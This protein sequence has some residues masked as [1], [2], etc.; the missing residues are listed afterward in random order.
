MSL[1]INEPQIDELDHRRVG[2]LLANLGTPDAPTA[3]AL[4]RF[5]REFLGDPRVIEEPRWKWWPILNLFIL[6]FRPRQSAALYRKIWQDDGSP[7]LRYSESLTAK[8][9][10]ALQSDLDVPVHVETGMRYG[11]PSLTEAL[12]S[13]R[14]KRCRRLLV[15]PMF[16]QY[17]GTTVASV[18]D[19]LAAE[20]TRWRVVPHLRMIQA[21]H[22]N[23]QYIEALAGSIRDVWQRDGEP[24][25]LLLS[26]HGIPLRYSTGGDPYHRQCLETA[27]LLRQSLGLDEERC[28]VSFQSI[29]GKEEWIQPATDA[30][31]ESLAKSGLHHLDVV[32]PGFSVDCLET[33]EE[34][35][36]LNR[37]IFL[38]NG[39]NRFRYI[40]CLNDSGRHVDMVTSLVRRNLAGWL[41]DDELD[42]EIGVEQWRQS[43]S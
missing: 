26:F 33:L 3:A 35:D 25:T 20:L 41:D 37:E 34:I 1:Y 19:A 13:L 28:R 22:D 21:Y 43:A 17:S 38:D 32:C 27:R 2:V 16:P 30:T 40:P 31:I 11:R 39:G 29:F 4:R 14:E 6:P 42:S 36:Q 12:A 23:P 24:D 18:F 7:L 5:L 9:R 8:V 10:A 15:L